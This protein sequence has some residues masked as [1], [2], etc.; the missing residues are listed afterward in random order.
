MHYLKLFLSEIQ[1]LK[2]HFTRSCINLQF[3]GKLQV[4]LRQVFYGEKSP[5]RGPSTAM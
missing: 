2:E 3:S 5:Y 4:V 1:M